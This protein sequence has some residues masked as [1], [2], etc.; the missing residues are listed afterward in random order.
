MGGLI[1][2]YHR[3]LKPRGL[4]HINVKALVGHFNHIVG[5]FSAKVCLKL[6]WGQMVGL[7]P[8]HNLAATLI[9]AQS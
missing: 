4:T 2:N 3:F 1:V 5:A 7:S 9:S 6:Y 8:D